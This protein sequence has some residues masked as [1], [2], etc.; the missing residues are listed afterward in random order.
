MKNRQ[1]AFTLVELMVTLAVA[2]ILAAVGL[3]LFDSMQANSRAVAVANGLST[4]LNMAR[5]EAV[6]Q[7]VAAAACAKNS[8]TPSD[9][10]CGVA[11]DWVN[12]WLVF[13]DTDRDGVVDG[14]EQVLK[15]WSSPAG[16]A[17]IDASAGVIR[18]SS[19][20]ELDVAAAT[21]ELT[22]DNAKGSQTRCISISAVGQI[23]VDRA[24]CP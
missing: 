14:S 2:I 3:P 13:Q 22:Q 16:G 19:R 18:F 10:V 4:A 23:R 1:Q 8:P 24:A 15:I 20:G 12:G 21:F 5:S 17:N 7:G 11:A 9:T 6:G